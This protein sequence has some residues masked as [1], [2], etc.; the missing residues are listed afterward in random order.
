MTALLDLPTSTVEYVHVTITAD[1]DP[2][3]DTVEMAFTAGIPAPA[4]WH[5]A[6]WVPDTTYDARILLGDTITL[7]AGTYTVWV[8][9]TDNPEIPVLRAGYLRLR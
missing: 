7:T 2:T 1:A 4:D 3:G 8:R 5:Q 6:E 9:V